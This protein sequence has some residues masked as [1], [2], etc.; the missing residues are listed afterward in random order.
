MIYGIVTSADTNPCNRLPVTTEGAPT[1]EYMW[2]CWSLAWGQD[3]WI[4]VKV[5]LFYVLIDHDG[6]EVQNLQNKNEA[7]I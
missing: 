4:V 2:V 6:I 1:E 7:N 3:G 5:F